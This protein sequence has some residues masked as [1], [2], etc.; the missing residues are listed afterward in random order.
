MSLS[1]KVSGMAG[2]GKST[3]AKIIVDALENAGFVAIQ[4]DQEDI[5]PHLLDLRIKSLKKDTVIFVSCTKD[6]KV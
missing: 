6:K 5:H 2:T 1:V 4:D 3:V